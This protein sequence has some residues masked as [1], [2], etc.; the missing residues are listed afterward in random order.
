[1]KRSLFLVVTFCL[2]ILQS[3]VA[4]TYTKG[5]WQISLDASQRTISIVQNGMTLV[6]DGHAEAMCASGTTDDMVLLSSRNAVS[7]EE[8]QAS[9]AD[10]LGIG[11]GFLFT[12]TF[13]NGMKMQQTFRVYDGANYIVARL[14]VTT[15]DGNS[16]RASQLKPVV[17]DNEVTFLPSGS[18][19]RMLFVPWDNDG[20]ISYGNYRML[21]KELYSYN[22]TAVYNYKTRQGLVVGAIDHDTWKS[23]IHVSASNSSSGN[24]LKNMEM[25]S[26][27]TDEHTHDSLLWRGDIVAHGAVV[28]DTV[29]SSRFLMAVFDDW[30]DGMDSFGDACN[31]VAPRRE[32]AGGAPV[33]WQSWGVMQTK[34]SY[35]GV[36]EVAEY[37]KDNLMAHGFYDKQGRVVM[38]LDAWWNDNFSDSQIQ[39]FVAYCKENNMIPGVYYGPFCLFS[40]LDQYVPGTSNKY[41]FSDIALKQGGLYKVVDGAYCLDPTHPGTKLFI[42]NDIAKFKRWGI[43]YLKCDFMSNGAIE[44]DSWY[45]TTHGS[46]HVYTGIQAYNMGMEYMMN[47]VGKNENGEDNIYIDLSIAPS[48]PYQYAHGR[49]ISCDAWG[50]IDHT[51]Y[52]MNNTSYGWW[53]DRVYV[54]NDPDGLVMNGAKSDSDGSLDTD[55]YASEA[56]N[57]SRLTSGII[58]GAY[59]TADNYSDK[60]ARG[61]VERS[62]M[63]AEKYLTNEKV[64]EIA[65]T[66]GTFRPV[67]GSETG[68]DAEKIFSYATDK[69]VYVAVFAYTNIFGNSGT[70][71]YERLGVDASNVASVEELWLGN[72]VSSSSTGFTYS[73]SYRDARLYRI[74]LNTSTGVGET[75][76]EEA[77]NDVVNVSIYDAGGRKVSSS[78]GANYAL[79]MAKGVYVVKKTLR[80]GTVSTQKK[81]R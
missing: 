20:F 69:Y 55:N 25:I 9:I 68:E 76:S 28:G 63:I 74:N 44:A 45:R 47:E 75:L 64:N 65:R 38:S 23:A 3:A 70:L 80:N 41:K 32:W 22:A 33:G 46:T 35:E 59:L 66:C 17:G 58:T 2:A 40:Y 62:K 43:E 48:F 11:T 36:M 77:G 60:V 79:P 19:N 78:N 16:V 29:R 1:M 81:M 67:E 7:V 34:V 21:N 49:R 26:G 5:V 52:V 39:Q 27:Y 37:I 4:S 8:Q 53:L 24:V 12:Y 51:K 56:V 30:R 73:V 71:T 61:D 18:D 42:R 15:G 54:A 14:S 10:K 50:T 13:S 6:Q 31:L 72:A 57:R